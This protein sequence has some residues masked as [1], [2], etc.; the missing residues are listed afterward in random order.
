MIITDVVKK[1]METW[2]NDSSI[3]AYCQTAFSK[4]PVFQDAIDENNP[5]GDE[6]FPLI[7]VYDWHSDG[8]M[9][10]STIKCQ[11]L[12]GIAIRDDGITVNDALRTKS[13]D[14]LGKVETL[15][16]LAELSLLSARLGKVSWDGGGEMLHSFP[17]FASLSVVT[18]EIPNIRPRI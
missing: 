10:S 14:G 18:I 8:G 1:I 13:Y 9:M 4:L 11:F 12:I 2:A 3:A 17:S 5:P 15:R 6:D 7:C 16:N